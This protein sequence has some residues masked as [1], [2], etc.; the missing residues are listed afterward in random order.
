MFQI[1]E[2]I[3]CHGDAVVCADTSEG[4]RFD[5]RADNWRLHGEF[6]LSF[7]LWESNWKKQTK[8]QA[9]LS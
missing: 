6:A 5:P 2:H 9:T 1:C 4:T 3:G 8:G 7:T